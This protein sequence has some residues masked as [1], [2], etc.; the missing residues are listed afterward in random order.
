MFIVKTIILKKD[1]IL[2]FIFTAGYPDRGKATE[3]EGRVKQGRP[4][5][6]TQLRSSL[7]ELNCLAELYNCIYRHVYLWGC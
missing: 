2:T 6:H 4:R 7:L 5:L 1:V 3:L